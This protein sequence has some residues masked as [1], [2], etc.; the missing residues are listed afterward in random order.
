MNKQ[1]ARKSRAAALTAAVVAAALFTTSAQATN[2]L[3]M[4]RGI[5]DGSPYTLISDGAAGRR[6]DVAV[7]QSDAWLERQLR[8]TDGVTE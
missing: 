5:S 4:V 2:N 8:T 6:G 7:E 3:E 1:F